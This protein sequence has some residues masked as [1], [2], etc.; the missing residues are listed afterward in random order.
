MLVVAVSQRDLA[1]VQGLVLVIA[2]TMVLANLAVD[3]L[4]GLLDPRIVPERLKPLVPQGVPSGRPTLHF[5]F[6]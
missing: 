1:V 4:Y 3:L 5:E 6:E 2:A